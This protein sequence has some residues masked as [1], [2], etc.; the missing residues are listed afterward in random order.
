MSCR[1]LPRF[2]MMAHEDYLHLAPFLPFPCAHVTG[3]A[4]VTGPPV[5]I[6]EFQCETIE[7]VFLSFKCRQQITNTPTTKHRKWLPPGGLTASWN[8]EFPALNKMATAFKL[9][10]FFR[11]ICAVLSSSSSYSGPSSP[12]S[13]Q[14]VSFLSFVFFFLFFFKK[15]AVGSVMDGQPLHT[16]QLRALHTY[17]QSQPEA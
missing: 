4:N 1:M 2:R 13:V 10:T 12:Q 17:I 11:C 8:K 5:L 14:V 3:P 15:R 9:L 16:L 6:N 7:H